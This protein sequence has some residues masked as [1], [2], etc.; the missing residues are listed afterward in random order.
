MTGDVICE[1]DIKGDEIAD[2]F[3]SRCPMQAK[4]ILGKEYEI[5]FIIE[6]I[7]GKGDMEFYFTQTG[8]LALACEYGNI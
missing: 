2:T 4:L 3:F 1:S 7:G 5:R 8:E 6:D